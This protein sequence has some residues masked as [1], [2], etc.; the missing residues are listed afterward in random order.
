MT[1]S[2]DLTQI[3]KEINTNEMIK[4]KNKERRKN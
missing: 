3:K 1:N 4:I 2:K